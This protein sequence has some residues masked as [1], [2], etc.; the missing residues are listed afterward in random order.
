[1]Y[2]F[3]YD[4][5]CLGLCMSLVL[6]GYVSIL[7]LILAPMVKGGKYASYSHAIHLHVHSIHRTFIGALNFLWVG[8]LLLA[9]LASI[10]TLLMLSFVLADPGE[11]HFDEWY[12]VLSLFGA[13]TLYPLLFGL[14]LKRYAKDRTEELH[15]IHQSGSG[16]W[17][18]PLA[19]LG[20]EER[21]EASRRALGFLRGARILTGW[22][23]AAA[24]FLV[25]WGT[26]DVVYIIMSSFLY[27]WLLLALAFVKYATAAI[28]MSGAD[29]LM[30]DPITRETFWRRFLMGERVAAGG[31]RR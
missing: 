28:L 13:M 18:G 25:L 21:P 10:P 22:C 27:D 17:S 7:I 3:I 2:D 26:F 20:E 6:V 31:D 24:I 5:V 16:P 15:G 14:A 1:M 19:R 30:L 23:C 11:E 12:V 9:V 29:R 4:E 8:F